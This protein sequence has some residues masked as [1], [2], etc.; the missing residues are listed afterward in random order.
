MSLIE[1]GINPVADDAL[2]LI[3]DGREVGGVEV[4]GLAQEVVR[5]TRALDAEKGKR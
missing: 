2:Q 1:R 3:M 5:L 4:I